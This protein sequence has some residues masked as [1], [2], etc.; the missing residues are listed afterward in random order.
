MKL[1]VFHCRECLRAVADSSNIEEY[2]PTTPKGLLSS[3]ITFSKINCQKRGPMLVHLRNVVSSEDAS[4]IWKESD[5]HIG[6]YIKCSCNERLGVYLHSSSDQFEHLRDL[7][8]LQFNKLSI[9]QIDIPF[10]EADTPKKTRMVSL[11]S[12]VLKLEND[13]NEMEL[14]Y[15]EL[16]AILK[17]TEDEHEEIIKRV[18]SNDILNSKHF[19]AATS[20]NTSMS[21]SSIS[22]LKRKKSNQTNPRVK[23]AKHDAELRTNRV[24]PKISYQDLMAMKNEQAKSKND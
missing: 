7:F 4:L 18:D 22:N 17:N 10:E 15:E 20:K 5:S 11:Y 2:T 16:R 9:Y 14:E 3:L 1:V 23:K 12:S 6:Y 13:I 8:C 24:L 19:S 21:N